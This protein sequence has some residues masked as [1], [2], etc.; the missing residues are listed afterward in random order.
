M[1][2]KIKDDVAE[3]AR[4]EKWQ[5]FRLIFV[6]VLLMLLFVAVG[7]RLYHLQT[8]EDHLSKRAQK[9]STGRVTLGAG[10]E[11]ELD[12]HRGYI[13][14]RQ[15]YELA[16]SVETPSV[17]A[18][19][20]QIKDKAAVAEKLAPVLGLSS[21]ELFKKLQS[22]ANFVWLVR[23][24]SPDKVAEL[25]S[26]KIPGI[27]FKRE[28]KR[29][30]PNQELA[31]QIL[32]F[33]GLD[34]VGLEGLEAA[35]DSVLRGGVLQ[36]KGTRD[37]RGRVIM[38]NETPRL[39]TLEGSS[40]ILT[41]D[42]YIQKVCETALE[43]YAK[44][45]AAKAGTAIVMDPKTGEILA[46][47]S[48][49]RF[50]P[51]LF[52]NYHKDLMRN[53]AVLDTY[54]PGSTMKIFTYAAAVDGAGVK[55]SEAINQE[56]GKLKIGMH[57]IT[58]T[59]T[60]PELSAEKVITYSSNIGAYKLAQR[61][62]RDKFY[63]YLKDFGFGARTGIKIAGE[64][65]GIL[66]K[67]D[68]WAEITFANIAFGHGISTSPLQL[69]VATS[70]IA[71]GG[72]LP[73]PYMI[74]EIRDHNGQIIQSGEAVMRRRVI[75]E[76]AAKI[77]RQALESVVTEGTGLRAWVGG[78]RVGGKT[79]TAQKVD[80]RTKAYSNKYMANF[81]GIAPIDEPDI[82]IVVQFDEPRKAYFGGTVAAPAF[83][84]I[85]SQVLP[86]RGVFPKDVYSGALNP[87]DSLLSF[88]KAPIAHNDSVAQIPEQAP[89]GR[90]RVPDLHGL[91]A[92]AAIEKA[93]S[94]GLELQIKD[95]GYVV[96]QWPS[97]GS[98]SYP[99]ARIEV[100]LEGKYRELQAN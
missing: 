6:G 29:Y 74:K 58:D 18:H 83:A 60:I 47:A 71:N 87:F 15:G 9:Q 52:K 67:P 85:A 90:V 2:A 39:N 97:A 77:T 56:R 92:Y 46:M 16:V 31:G 35:Y 5:K 86:Y 78:Y 41:I 66:W 80:P 40:I 96:S 20:K 89:E 4:R 70:A 44:E 81:V 62:G 3:A 94:V 22:K 68:K 64:S 100:K 32:G 76:K 25:K 8:Q 95:H 84:E 99:M 7:A 33:V 1:K 75:S 55:A 82:V 12:G 53:R 48:Y 24:T 37:A 72:E 73:T 23:K 14:D 28:S 50:N 79:G 91:T 34:N 11:N 36:L 10:G 98:L 65:A 69:A 30:Y 93:Q 19:P 21:E 17:Y 49:P 63:A 43:R 27:G 54:E 57:T 13:Y 51:N 61:L 38:T 88:Y 59:H 26:L 45:H 42:Q